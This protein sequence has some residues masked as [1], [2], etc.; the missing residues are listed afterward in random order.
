MI[1]SKNKLPTMKADPTIEQFIKG[2]DLRHD[3]NGPRG[4]DLEI[5]C[6]KLFYPELTEDELIDLPM[7]KFNQMI[8]ISWINN[9]VPLETF[10]LHGVIWKYKRSPGTVGFA[11]T[12]R[13]TKAAMAAIVAADNTWGYMHYILNALYEPASPVRDPVAAL[14]DAKLSWAMPFVFQIK[15]HGLQQSLDQLH[16]QE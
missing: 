15:Q 16:A 12:I 10:A 3:P 11:L 9:A 13:Q 8:D 4:I 6:A 14:L 2:V 5:E 1:D 7:G